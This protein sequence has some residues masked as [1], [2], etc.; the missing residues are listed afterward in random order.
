[1]TSLKTAG[2]IAF[3][4][5]TTSLVCGCGPSLKE[6]VAKSSSYYSQI[7]ASS[8]VDVRIEPRNVAPQGRSVLG[9]IGAAVNVAASV[10][11]AVVSTQQEERLQRIISSKEMATQ[12]ASGFDNNFTGTTHLQVVDN[13]ANPDIRIM[14]RM[15]KFGIWAES[16]L[17]PLNFYVEAEVQIVYT[18]SLETIYSSGVS[19]YREAANVFS[20]VANSTQIEVHGG[21]YSAMH[22]VSDVSRLVSGAANLT[23]FFEM[24]DEEVQAVFD[25]MAYDAGTTIASKLVK[26]IYN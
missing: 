24:T 13:S 23:A 10:G 18:P 5:A 17:S 6:Y 15:N 4:L 21:G 26:A 20:E 25:Y 19:I 9:S 2:L 8:K 14:L 3:S 11:S 16:M 12:V 7:S 1:M 22:A